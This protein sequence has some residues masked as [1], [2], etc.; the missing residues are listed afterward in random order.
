MKPRRDVHQRRA[1]A[2]RRASL[3]VDRV[4]VAKSRAERDR[5]SLWARAWGARAGWRSAQD[6]LGAAA[7]G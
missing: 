7:S 6:L 1:Y 4:I 2:E 3:A 5:A